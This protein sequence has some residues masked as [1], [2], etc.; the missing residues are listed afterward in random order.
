MLENIDYFHY[1]F[2]DLN[3]PIIWKDP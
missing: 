2:R 3:P 1:I